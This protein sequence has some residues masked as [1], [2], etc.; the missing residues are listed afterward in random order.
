MPVRFL[1]AQAR[2]T[3]ALMMREIITR[4]GREGGGF[5][6]LIGEPLMFCI[7]VIVMWSVLKPAYEHGIHVGAFVMTGYMCLVLMRHVINYTMNA[8]QANIGMLYHRQVSVLH[9]IIS[10]VLLELCGSSIAFAIV[11]VALLLL[12]QV[13][14]PSDIG[15]LYQGWFSLFWLA[16]GM[17]LIMSALAM[18]FEIVERIVG[19]FM[20]LLIPVSGVFVM[21]AW[22]PPS[23]RQL[24]LLVPIP[25]T[26]EMVRAGVFGEFV[27]TY[28]DPLYPV[29]WGTGFVVIG[30]ILLSTA[31]KHIDVE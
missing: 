14:V 5:L 13:G 31:V 2:I 26:V 8:V 17:G 18:R 19:I 16:T 29:A 20:Y 15:L 27:Q 11:Y 23:Y 3:G 9:L 21:V 25:H 22:L 12:D 7:G 4:F 1:R 30:L 10:R 28:Y 24:Y 6:W